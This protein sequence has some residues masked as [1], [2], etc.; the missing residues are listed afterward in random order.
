LVIQDGSP[1]LQTAMR[2]SRSPRY[3]LPLHKA[4]A[5]IIWLTAD[6]TKLDVIGSP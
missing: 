2:M 6:S 1:H 4:L 3:M 5:V